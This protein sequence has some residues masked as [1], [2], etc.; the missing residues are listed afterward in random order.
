L[1]LDNEFLSIQQPLPFAKGWLLIEIMPGTNS[2]EII[3]ADKRNNFFNAS[4]L[5]F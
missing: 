5:I 3:M 2:S 1:L 4:L